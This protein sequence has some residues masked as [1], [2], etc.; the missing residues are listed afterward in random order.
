M[1]R[2][3]YVYLFICLPHVGPGYGVEV[4]IFTLQVFIVPN[5][6]WHGQAPL[7]LSW[8]FFRPRQCRDVNYNGIN[9]LS[10]TTIWWRDIYYII[11]YI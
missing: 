11:Y 2:D 10:N 9:L 5:Q 7:T 4:Q 3:E 8:S 1:R 6:R